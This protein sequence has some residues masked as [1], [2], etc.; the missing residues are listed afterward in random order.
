MCCHELFN[1]V[2]FEEDKDFLF[3]NGDFLRVDFV[4]DCVVV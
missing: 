2:L 4:L 1:F 3:S